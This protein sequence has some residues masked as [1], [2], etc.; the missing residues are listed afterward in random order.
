M[1]AVK[2]I[3]FSSLVLATSISFQLNCESELEKRSRETVPIENNTEEK[4]TSDGTHILADFW[5]CNI[6]QDPKELE[7]ILIQAAKESKSTPLEV[8][9]HKFEP[10]GITGIII[11]GESH[12]SIHYAPELDGY[13]AIDAFTCGK[14]TDPHAAIEFLIKIF[15]PQKAATKE[16]KRGI[17][18]K[19]I[20]IEKVFGQELTLDLYDCTPETIRSKEKILEFSEKL[21]DLIEM[22]RYGTP[23]CERFA[24]HSE[25]AAGYSLA[26]MIETSLVSG[27]F[28]EF[29]NRAYI[30]IFSC[31]DFDAEKAKK[32][33]QEF[34]GAKEVK[35]N[36]A[37]R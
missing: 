6:T 36:V 17:K 24:E 3:L 13:A 34:F 16:V 26:Q 27:H 5:G 28:S 33:T 15:K 35:S 21:C 22:K 25:I 30:N 31:K 2:K 11:L 18:E 23:F 7:T 1:K 32:F 4:F 12:I 9:I 37:I 20:E 8:S 29:L 10:Q 19:P 14:N